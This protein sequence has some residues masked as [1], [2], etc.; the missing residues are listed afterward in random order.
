MRN[1]QIRKEIIDVVENSYEYGRG[2]IS[3][4]SLSLVTEFLLLYSRFERKCIKEAGYDNIYDLIDKIDETVLSEDFPRQEIMDYFRKRYVK[5]GKE[6][7]TFAKL[8]FENKSKSRKGRELC[9]RIL[10]NGGNE[11]EELKCMLHII[12]RYRNNL[13]HGSKPFI[14][15]ESQKE[16]F[17]MSYKVLI[18]LIKKY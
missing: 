17:E 10:I 5:E 13:F 7:T 9:K 2:N 1:I 3:D 18:E 8:K 12:Y 15:I 6:N 14:D 11:S 4:R 16:N